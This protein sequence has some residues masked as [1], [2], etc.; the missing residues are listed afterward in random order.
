MRSCH[1]SG[2][3]FA[4]SAT[5]SRPG[6]AG[7]GVHVQPAVPP[8]PGAG[9]GVR[10]DL[11]RLQVGGRQVGCGQVGD[12]QVVA[13]LRTARRADGQPPA[14]PAH[15]RRIVRGLVASRTEDQ[16]VVL[17]WRAHPMQVDAAVEL[18][19]A[20]GHL[21]GRQPPGVVERLAARQPCDPGVAAA[22]DRAVHQLA[23]FHVHH[24]EQRFLAAPFGQLVGEGPAFLVRLPA[25]KRGPPARVDGDRVDQ[26]PPAVRPGRARALPWIARVLLWIEGAQDGVLLAGQAPGEELPGLPPHWHPDVPGPGQFQDP[27]RQRGHSRQ[28]LLVRA[29]Q[30]VLGPQPRTRLLAVRVLEPSVGI[31]DLMAEQ[32]LDEVEPPGV[33]VLICGH[34]RH[35]N[36]PP[37]RSRPPRGAGD[38]EW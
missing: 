4:G 18:L 17:G 35:P 2:W 34:D 19:F 13:G 24:P 25:V 30:V 12:P 29:E 26:R 10:P 7:V 37:L 32:I 6:G 28:L 15:G 1:P 38:G 27:F 3:G 11:H 33:R 5:A 22:V 31:A 8:D 23:G 21:A 14:V 9:P 20:G 16:H 36:V